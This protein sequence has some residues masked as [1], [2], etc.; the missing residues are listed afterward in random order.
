M[1]S[2]LDPAVV[3]ERGL[4]HPEALTAAERLVFLLMEFETLMNMEGWDDFFTS[5]WSHYYPEMKQGLGA[6]GDTDSL[7]VLQDYERHLQERN[8]ALEPRAIDSF[9]AAQDDEYFKKCRDW[10]E[11]Y[12]ELS[13][14]RWSKVRDYLGKLGFELRA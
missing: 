6:A 8:V 3:Y 12:G 1:A 11:D 9:L 10:R 4:R 5:R 2:A 13:E 14:K 7:E